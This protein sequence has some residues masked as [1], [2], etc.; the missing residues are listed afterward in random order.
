MDKYTET[1][2][3]ER[4]RRKMEGI[5]IRDEEEVKRVFI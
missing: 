3:D 1:R 5:F 2:E 4:G